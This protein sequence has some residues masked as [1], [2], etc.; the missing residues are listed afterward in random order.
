[1]KQ[2]TS[3]VTLL[4]A[5]ISYVSNA[6]QSFNKTAYI[7]PYKLVVTTN[8]TTNILFPSAIISIDRGSQDIMVQKAN[9]VENILRVKAD[10]KDFE[11]TNLSI[12]TSDGKLYS[13]LVNYANN[14]VYLSINL[15]NNISDT[16]TSVKQPAII[17]TEPVMDKN[18]LVDYTNKAVTAKDNIHALN[19]T[20]SYISLTIKGFYS[21]GNTLFCKMHLGNRSQIDYDIEQ[22]RFY[23]KDKKQSKRTS[24][25]EIEIKP[26][27]ISGIT[28]TL[29]GNTNGVLVAALPK[30]TISDGKYLVVE[31]IEKKGGR[32]LS[33]KAKNR[34]LAKARRLA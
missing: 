9:G 21:K 34:H 25:Q 7:Q 11:E 20:D 26:L 17:Y 2:I 5:L 33:I 24:S 15:G 18:S 32:H 16:N 12:I 8:K 30:F 23:I 13:F 28:N 29:V 22:F 1:M 31:I 14:P 4:L 3:I 6:Q 19:K 10:V 27:Y